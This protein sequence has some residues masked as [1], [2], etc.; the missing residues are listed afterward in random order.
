MGLRKDLSRLCTCGWMGMSICILGSLLLPARVKHQL[1]LCSSHPLLCLD[2]SG[3]L[4]RRQISST[5]ARQFLIIGTM[6]S[7][8]TQMALQL[9]RLGLEVAHESSDARI[10]RCRDGTVSWAHALRFVPPHPRVANGLCAAPLDGAWGPGMYDTSGV[11]QCLRWPS[12]SGDYWDGCWE[13]ACRKL[14]AD[15]LGCFVTDPSSTRTSNASTNGAPSAPASI[16]RGRCKTPYAMTLLQVRHPLHTIA[17]QIAAFCDGLDTASAAAA[18]T[19]LRALN[20]LMPPPQHEPS[21]DRG[22]C[23][24]RF[25]WAWVRYHHIARP[26]A[27]AVYQVEQTSACEILRLAGIIPSRSA[28]TATQ[29][30]ASVAAEAFTASQQR[31]VYLPRSL[32]P[33]ERAA[34]AHAACLTQEGLLKSERPDRSGPKKAVTHLTQPSADGHGVINR[35]NVG[36]RRTN[37]SI[38][39]V[40][41]TSQ[42]LALEITRLAHQLGY[43]LW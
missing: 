11:M 34:Q 6:G 33:P 15:E 20:A 25:G 14:V 19:Q 24:R 10:T 17:S 26:H 31:D 37:V 27:H 8:T 3:F 1:R 42:R 23:T 39:V 12:G 22:E 4:G 21:V 38:A 43:T 7:G 13:N 35:R 18:S 29:A 40:A 5:D 2:L 41:R 28:A 30:V 16:S 32:V 9:R 36:R